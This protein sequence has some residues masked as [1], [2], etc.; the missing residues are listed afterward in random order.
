MKIQLLRLFIAIALLGAVY[1]ACRKESVE[2]PA[3]FDP[4]SVLH[5][6]VAYLNSISRTLYVVPG[7]EGEF[8]FAFGAQELNQGLYSLPPTTTLPE[9]MTFKIAYSDI[10]SIN[11]V[12]TEEDPILFD[13]EKNEPAAPRFAAVEFKDVD[14]TEEVKK[15]AE[16]KCT[17]SR[18]QG[19]DI[20]YKVVIE[21]DFT[22]CKEAKGKTCKAER[23]EVAKL[24]LFEAKDCDD[25]KKEV[26]REPFYEW[27]CK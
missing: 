20:A 6:R 24:I 26:S 19:K 22:R 10:E 21:K 8:L 27:V 2:E 23:K 4:A 9:G 13:M 14:C 16:S 15:G 3:A 1:S 18:V 7:Y 5:D 17:S 12:A 11:A 25:E